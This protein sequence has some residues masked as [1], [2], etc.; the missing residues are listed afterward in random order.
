MFRVCGWCGG[1]ACASAQGE[2][3]LGG[4]A[5]EVAS[6]ALGGRFAGLRRPP[7]VSRRRDAE[8]GKPSPHPSRFTRFAR[9][10]DY[11]TQN[12]RSAHQ[13]DTLALS[14]GGHT[15]SHDRYRP[16]QAEDNTHGAPTPIS[17]PQQRYYI[18]ARGGSDPPQQRYKQARGGVQPPP[19]EIR[20]N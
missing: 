17:R 4:K 10:Q 14:C 16:R 9:L 11:K 19:A 12:T 5:G 18:H 6:K 8:R 20:T 15:T 3:R 7:D 2:S 13:L 1:A